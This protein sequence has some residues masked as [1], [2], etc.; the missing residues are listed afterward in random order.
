MESKRQKGRR[1]LFG[2]PFPSEVLSPD[3]CDLTRASAG[4][5]ILPTARKRFL[6]TCWSSRRPLPLSLGLSHIPFLL[7]PTSP[8]SGICVFRIGTDVPF[9]R[10]YCEHFMLVRCLQ[11]GGTHTFLSQK[12]SRE[13]SDGLLTQSSIRPLMRQEAR[14]LSR[15]KI[16]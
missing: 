7:I 11:G 14:N 4:A 13:G 16:K 2:T 8:L 5:G 12:E 3:A 15:L 10:F 1:V 9:I 6:S